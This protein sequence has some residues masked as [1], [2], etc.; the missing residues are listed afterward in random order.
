MNFHYSCIAL[1]KGLKHLCYDFVSYSILFVTSDFLVRQVCNRTALIEQQLVGQFWQSSGVSLRRF[2]VGL[3]LSYY[4]V[5]KASKGAK[6]PP[7]ESRR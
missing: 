4:G 7:I 6:I 1:V 3:G 2:Y 5:K